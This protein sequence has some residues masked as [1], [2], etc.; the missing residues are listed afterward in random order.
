MINSI[1]KQIEDIIL[2]SKGGDLFLIADFKDIGT[3]TAIRKS[4]SRF[5]ELGIIERMG[6]GIYVIPKQHKIFGKILPS[7]EEVA[8]ILAEKEHVRIM[9]SGQY[10]LNRIGLSNQVPMKLIFL[11]NGTFKKI[12]FGKSELIFK[13]TT[14]KKLAMKGEITS[15]LLY[16]YFLRF[17]YMNGLTTRI[18]ARSNGLFLVFLGLLACSARPITFVW[19]I[20]VTLFAYFDYSLSNEFN[21]R[22]FV[23]VVSISLP[24]IVLGLLWKIKASVDVLPTVVPLDSFADIWH[25]ATQIFSLLPER[26]MQMFGILGWLDTRPPLFV[27]QIIFILL[28]LF[29]WKILRTKS[30]KSLIIWGAF[31]L[32][33]TIV[34]IAIEIPQWTYWPNFWQGRYSLP[35]FSSLLLILLGGARK[36][37]F[38]LVRALGQISMI[39][40]AVFVYINFL[41]YAYGLNADGFPTRFDST[42][43]L[44][45]SW[46]LGTIFSLILFFL[47]NLNHL[48]TLGSLSQSKFNQIKK[49]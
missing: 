5:V 13:P 20:I 16:T 48:R 39:A 32:I 22:T 12:Q 35:M 6:K 36:A 37:D 8:A 23:N 18:T 3:T 21:F 15:L 17:E 46:V 1:N 25:V 45:F 43:G 2:N 40:S 30:G 4:L 7:L 27:Y 42:P 44:P 34:P 14:N 29:V 38:Q 33:I 9:P 41:R 47:L 26:T 49:K 19:L 28:M 11:T 10:A 31:L 24:G